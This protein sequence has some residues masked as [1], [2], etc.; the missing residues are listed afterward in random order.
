MFPGTASPN[1]R[2]QR[3]ALRAAAE[4]ER[5]RAEPS[6]ALLWRCWPLRSSKTRTTIVQRLGQRSETCLRL[7][8]L[9]KSLLLK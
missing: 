1:N 2:L 9:E 6:S 7:P 3:T 5:C 8:M 4:P